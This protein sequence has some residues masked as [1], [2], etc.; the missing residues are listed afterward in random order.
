MSEYKH[1]KLSNDEQNI[2][3]LTI[4][5]ADAS[6][7]SLSSDVLNE[8]NGILDQLHANNPKGL[9]IQSAKSSGFIAGADINELA[10]AED[11]EQ[12][13]A[14][15][16][17]GQNV[18]S[19]I[20]SLRCPTVA[21]ISGFCLGGGAELALAC[22]YR[23][24][25]EDEKTKIGFPEVRL[26]IFPAFGGSARL[27]ILIGA[28]AALGLMLAGNSLSA[29]AAKK[30]G[31]IDYALPQR[32]L[33]SAARDII[34][35][36]PVPARAGGW[37]ALTNHSL[38]RPLLAPI[39]R[40]K[41]AEK[42]REKHYPAP[43]ALIDLWAS[44]GGDKK[45]MLIGEQRVV[46]KLAVGQ[47]CKNLIRVYFL[48]EALKHTG[49]KSMFKPLRVH[50]IGAGVMGGDIAAWCALQGYLVTMQDR[51]EQVLA[52]AIKR[53]NALYSKKLKKPNLVQGVLDRLTPDING[54]GIAQADVIIEAIIEN[55]EAKQGLFKDLETKAKKDAVLAT[56]TS[57]IPLESISEVMK[58]PGRLVGI[59]FFNPVAQ[60]QLVEIVYGGKTQK[61]EIDKATAFTRHIN[62]LPLPVKSSPGFLVN[63][64][65]MPY[66]LEAVVL[67]SE[68][69]SAAVIDEAALDFGMPMGPITLADTVGLDI[70][71][72]VAENLSKTMAVEVP[73][74]LRTLVDAGRL[75]V[76]SGHGFYVYKGRKA[77]NSAPNKTDYRPADIQDRLILRMINE[78][79]ACLREG[80]V[81]EVDLIDAG[82]IFATGFA[83]FTGGPLHYRDATQSLHDTLL[84]LE[85]KYGPRFKPDAGWAEV[86]SAKQTDAA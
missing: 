29:R 1:W 27:P 54:L 9:V 4:D 86:A 43:Y 47:T 55:L 53:A 34:N 61:S 78:T 11:R 26:G 65:L 81:R 21:L 20:E 71:L 18:L 37:K 74:R 36:P 24:A 2:T 22:R 14:F 50:V 42:A 85:E 67:E 6:A 16:Q 38:V 76:K 83:P 41:V 60:M 33:I 13:R 40:R 79:V 46:S 68:G 70:C 19:K 57:S 3:W 66:L 23:I 82:I 31:L 45:Q 25:N 10:K 15:I 72:S 17:L 63:R 49:D 75:G 62:R 48:Q 12:A 69:I 39:F 59:H 73:K 44:H 8:L 28:P 35:K 77:Q 7:N 30:M 80:I 51:S 58:N 32:H 64:V 84:K 52:Q 56:N 5:K